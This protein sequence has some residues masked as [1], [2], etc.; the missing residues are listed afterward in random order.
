MPDIFTPD[1]SV[2]RKF[3]KTKKIKKVLFCGSLVCRPLVKPVLQM[4]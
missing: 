3:E 4:H 2:T 1:F